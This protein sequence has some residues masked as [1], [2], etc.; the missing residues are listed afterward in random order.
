MDLAR[1]RIDLRVVPRPL[2]ALNGDAGHSFTVKGPLS[3]P[4]IALAAGGADLRGNYGCD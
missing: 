3:H 2:N 4:A 1:N